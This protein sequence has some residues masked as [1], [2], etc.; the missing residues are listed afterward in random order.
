MVELEGDST[1]TFKLEIVTAGRTYPVR[2]IISVDVPSELGRL[3]VLAGHEQLVCSLAGGMVKIV[4][5]SGK[6]E[7]W[8]VG[9]GSMSVISGKATILA[10]FAGPAH[11][12]HEAS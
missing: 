11:I 4:A 5:S 10:R 8:Q 7:M 3:T 6:E 1:H 2:D 12:I 9:P